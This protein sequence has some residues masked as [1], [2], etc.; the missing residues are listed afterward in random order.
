MKLVIRN[1]V[2]KFLFSAVLF[3]KPSKALLTCDTL[4]NVDGGTAP[5]NPFG[6]S[7]A[8]VGWRLVG[9]FDKGIAIPSYWRSLL[10]SDQEKFK[11]SW[12]EVYQKFDFSTVVMAHGNPV[13][14]PNVREDVTKAL[15]ELLK[16]K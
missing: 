9:I 14:K 5:K 11:Q 10:L 2:F 8:A 16:E 7:L 4:F 1:F 12:N 3:H 15:K 6:F 13:I